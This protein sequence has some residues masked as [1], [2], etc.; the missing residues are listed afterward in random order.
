M[1]TL[2]E[3]EATEEEEE[4]ER[5]LYRWREEEERQEEAW[6]QSVIDRY[7]RD[8]EEEERQNAAAEPPAATPA[9]RKTTSASSCSLTNRASNTDPASSSREH[10][11]TDGKQ[12]RASRRSPAQGENQQP[13]KKLKQCTASIREAIRISNMLA[14]P[15]PG[16]R[17][18]TQ[19]ELQQDLGTLL[20]LFQQAQRELQTLRPATTGAAHTCRGTRACAEAI[21]LLHDMLNGPPLGKDAT[22][23][24]NLLAQLGAQG[25]VCMAA[26]MES[27]EEGQI[28]SEA[29]QKVHPADVLG[30]AAGGEDT[31]AGR[32]QGTGSQSLQQARQ[33]LVHVMPFLETNQASMV[34]EAIGHMDAWLGMMFGASTV[35]VEDSQDSAG[36]AT[37]SEGNQGN[38]NGEHSAQGPPMGESGQ[39]Q[40]A[41]EPITQETQPWPPRTTSTTSTESGQ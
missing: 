27:G 4:Q 5:A 1:P 16:Q 36:L 38:V 21:D 13:R 9:E 24:G 39:P 41:G 20:Q 22:L 19:D 2:S 25:E 10:Q 30:L 15:A 11:E 37:G 40:N 6:H 23:L 31:H 14:T 34:Q 17:P 7:Y 32:K 26:M 8:K 33:Q 12:G 18:L 29:E 35:M 28:Q 3:E